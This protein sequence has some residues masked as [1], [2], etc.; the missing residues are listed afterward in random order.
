V[1]DTNVLIYDV[2]ED[3][4]LH[5]VARDLLDNLKRWLIPT[6]TVYDFKDQNFDV[7]ETKELLEQYIRSPKCKVIPDN[8]DQSFRIV[9]R[10]IPF[11]SNV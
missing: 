4:K 3:S 1:I 10:F 9:R 8:G 5:S 7:E 6:I 11:K 2:V